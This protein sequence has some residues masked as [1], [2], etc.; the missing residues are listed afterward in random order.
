MR[1]KDL[2]YPGKY[3]AGKRLRG[4][5]GTPGG[6]IPSATGDEDSTTFREWVNLVLD[7]E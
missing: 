1:I 3:P 2:S 7:R 6:Q 4:S 5:Q